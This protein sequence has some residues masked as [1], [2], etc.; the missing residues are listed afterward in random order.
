MNINPREM[1]PSAEGPVSQL[2]GYCQP[3]AAWLLLSALPEQ[4]RRH[5]CYVVTPANVLIGDDAFVLWPQE[6][7]E[8][9]SPFCPPEVVAGRRLVAGSHRVS[10]RH[11][12]DD[13]EQPRRTGAAATL[14]GAVHAVARRLGTPQSARPAMPQLPAAAAPLAQRDRNPC[15]SAVRLLAPPRDATPGAET[16]CRPFQQRSCRQ[17]P[18]ARADEGHRSGAPLLVPPLSSLAPA[19][20]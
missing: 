16:H 17:R 10:A 3:A 11:G 6:G 12:T 19:P 4:M 1:P 9:Q 7:Y 5:Q 14:K 2:A 18:V 15:P 20:S 13:D 8:P